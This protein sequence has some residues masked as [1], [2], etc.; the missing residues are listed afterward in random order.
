MP[1]YG[2]LGPQEL[3]SEARSFYYRELNVQVLKCRSNLSILRA[4]LLGVRREKTFYFTI[5][6]EVIEEGMGG[7]CHLMTL[8]TRSATL[9]STE[10][11]TKARPYPWRD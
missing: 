9:R 6:I 1:D 8:S 3:W 2:K 7:G 10:A 11:L 4:H 5:E